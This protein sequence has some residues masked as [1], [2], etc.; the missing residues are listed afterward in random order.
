MK[1][2]NKFKLILLVSFILL[3]SSVITA[4]SF[5][6]YALYNMLNS[7]DT[8]LVDDQANVVKTWTNPN[9]KGNY[10]VHLKEDGNLIRGGD[11]GNTTFSGG[12]IGGIIQE[13]DPNGSIVWEFVYSSS[14][15][16]SHHD[17]CVLPNGNVILTA[18]EIKTGTEL[19]AA[20]W[21]GS[22]SDKWPTHFIEVEPDGNG[23][24]SI[25][26]EWHIWDHLCQDY[27]ASKANY[28][29]SISANPQ[30]MDI[31]A[32]TG[33][34]GPPGPGGSS[35]DWFHV[36]GVDYNPTLDQLVF[37][38]RMASEI[39][40]ID[41]ST[42][43]AEAASHSGGNSGM[44][45]DFL[46]RYGNSNN[47]DSGSQIIPEAVHDPRW[48]K[49]GRPNAG[50][51]QFFNNA[52][53][54]NNSSTVEAINPP[55]TGYTYSSYTSPSSAALTHTAQAY[56]SGQSSSD[57]MTD[58]NIFVNV[59]GSHMYEV[60]STGT[61][62]FFNGDGP[63]KAFRFE[64][65]Y[66]GLDVVLGVGHCGTVGVEEF[67]ELNLKVFPNPSNGV[68]NIMGL[69]NT[70]ETFTVNV[71]DVSGKQILQT[72]DN[73]RIDLSDFDN[74]LY[75]VYITNESGETVVKKVS[76]MK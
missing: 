9:Y 50:Y 69:S 6:G 20:G 47:F 34:G 73:T 45:G 26:W 71:Y 63:G 5:N 4:Q 18:Y 32:V 46:Y 75:V 51:I 12:A 41:H 28:V 49:D 67:S 22:T 3:S 10:S 33:G 74:G 42:T 54:G 19:A 48:I 60:T 29:T 11:Y 72:N 16:V 17:F 30:L 64:C 37:S 15:V 53:G 65:D 31:N 61:Q 13:I 39:F 27:N 23:G 40:I 66:A 52:G 8:K 25:I 7:Y 38:S 14:S 68:F 21:S 58:G 59:S 43:T 44:G 62:V 70:I 36:N 35:G 1:T 56:S 24:A 76:L 2:L 55:V 57:R